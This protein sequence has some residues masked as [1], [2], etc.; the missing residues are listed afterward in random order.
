MTGFWQVI[1]GLF[2]SWKFWILK[3]KIV[4]SQY[5]IE[6]NIYL[7]NQFSHTALYYLFNQPI[8]KE[9]LKVFDAV[10][11]IGQEAQHIPVPRIR[12]ICRTW[13]YQCR[14]AQEVHEPA[15]IFGFILLKAGVNGGTGVMWRGLLLLAG[16]NRME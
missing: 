2:E 1:V 10:K 8:V 16:R 7:F 5:I 13:T 3:N 9:Y 6:F 12:L 14:R 15:A 11:F 4:Y